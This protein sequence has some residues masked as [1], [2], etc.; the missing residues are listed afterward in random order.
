M[1]T[2]TTTA[3]AANKLVK[4]GAQLPYRAASLTALVRGIEKND[5]DALV[6]LYHRYYKG[7]LWLC[8]RLT[9]R[10]HNEDAAQQTFLH[11]IEFVQQGKVREPERF[12]GLIRSIAKHVCFAIFE[13]EVIRPK[14]VEF[15]GGN[16]ENERPI[17]AKEESPEQQV[18]AR[19]KADIVRKVLWSMNPRDREILE[20]F[21]L[22]EETQEEICS[23]MG[24]NNTQF[25]LL[26]SRAKNR[27]G[28]AGKKGMHGNLV[29]RF[30]KMVAA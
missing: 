7:V 15:F 27:F 18:L 25:R 20:R 5:A 9:G 4:G 17:P 13:N 14:T 19:E 28:L 16:P 21:Y 10:E 3:M 8:C 11:V 6:E 29:A 1:A 26:K 24:L 30:K 2:I 22:R 12:S 23:A